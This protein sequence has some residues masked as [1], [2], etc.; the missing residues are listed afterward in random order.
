M[1]NLIRMDLHR[2]FLARSFK[3]CLVLSFL[4]GFI[5]V[6]AA[7]V[8]M[9]L[10]RILPESA[11]I[12]DLLPKSADLS[13]LLRDPFPL[14]N[15]MLLLF[16]ACYFYHADLEHGYI[17]NIAG[18]MPKRGYAV[19]SRYI[20]LIVHNLIFVLT[21]MAGNL[22]GT[23]LFIKITPDS[24]AVSALGYLGIRLLLLHGICAILLLFTTSLRSKN[25][26]MVLAVIFGANMM[27]VLYMGIDAGLGIL[28]KR[29]VSIENYMPDYL[30]WQ[31]T[32]D[33]VIALPVAAVT[34][35]I[36]V[37]LSVR[38]FDRRDVK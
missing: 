27:R 9:M 18:Q 10:V 3:V 32:P 23:V 38:I 1:S 11:G 36:F 16:S 12:P 6:P 34:I 7:K 8:F 19:L 30:M 2:M 15:G 28:L 4:S 33:P 37:L 22:I 29:S 20:A 35:V 25:F 14:M 24:E 21:G 5:I 17:K 31:E 13:S 26:G